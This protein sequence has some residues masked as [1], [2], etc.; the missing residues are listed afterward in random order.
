[1]LKAGDFD[2]LQESG[3]VLVSHDARFRSIRPRECAAHAVNIP[4]FQPTPMH[5]RSGA[6]R[7]ALSFCA[8][9]LPAVPL[10]VHALPAGGQVAA[11]NVAITQTGNTMTLQQGSPHAIVNWQSFGIGAG[12]HLHLQQNGAD[13]AML[14]RVIGSDP[15][16][17]LGTLK[18]DG[19]LFL[20]NRNGILVGAGA[21]I[22]TAAFL[23]STL[24]VADADFLK[25]GALTL[26]GDSTAGVVNL[27]KITAREG[28]VLLLA[29]TVKNAG[30]ISAPNGTAGLGAG[31]EVFLASPDAPAFV[32]K[33]NLTRAPGETA[34]NTGV[35]NSGVIAA[36]QA[37][38]EAAGGSLYDLAVN[39]SGVIKATGLE[40]QPDGRILLTSAGGNVAVSGTAIAHNANG[41]GGEILIGGD[42]QG[43]NAAIANAANTQI[44]SSASLDASATAASADG[45]RV[46]VWAD[47]TTHY[48]GALSARGGATGGDGGFAEVSGKRRLAFAGTS[49]LSAPA[50]QRGTLLLDPDN[51]T[52]VAGS[53]DVP[54]EI[55]ISPPVVTWD[56]HANAGEDHEFG[57]D[58]LVALLANNSVW[59][60]AT[61][62]ITVNAPV[63]VASGGLEGAGLSFSASA[64][65]INATVSLANV[66]DG[67]LTFSHSFGG[68][69]TSLT[70]AA[71]A[72]IAA[73]SI[74]VGSFPITAF[75]GVVST[76]SLTYNGFSTATSFSATNP[77]NAIGK[78][79]LNTDLAD[80]QAIPFT[81]NVAVHSGTGMT[82]SAMI[83]GANDVTFSSAGDLT[84]RND[85]T[86]VSVITASGTTKLASTGGVLVNEVGPDL[87]AGTG[88]K[89]LYTSTT[90]DG[91]GF[92]LGGLSNFQRVSGVS[93]PDDPRDDLSKVLYRLDGL[94]TIAADD[95]SKTYGAA[96]PTFTATYTGGSDTDLIVLP[97]F[98]IQEGSATNVG[99][100]TIV[101]SGATADYHDIAYVNGTLTIDPATLTYVAT[102]ATR[103]IVASDP[104]FSGTVTGFVNG[105]TLET[106]TTGT[107][108]FSTTATDSSPAGTYALNGS[109]LSAL[110]G[111]YVFVQA[112]ANATAFT[113]TQAGLIVITADSFT[114]LYGQPNPS[115]TASYS[116]GTASDLTIL[117]Q[118]SIT[119]GPAINVGTYEIVPFGADSNTHSLSY[120]NGT[121][122]IDPAILT[123]VAAP[124]TRTMVGSNP[125][126]SGTVTGFVNGD[127]LDTAT[128]G[129]LVFATN[130][131]DSSPAGTYALN[132]SGLNA[133]HGNYVF[134]QA[135][136][137]ANAFSITSAPQLI[138]RANDFT[139]LYGAPLPEFTASYSGG[140]AANL[141]ALPTFSIQG[142]SAVNVG[143]YVIVPSGA[144][145]NTHA[146]SYVN[147][148]FT[149]TPATLTY[150]AH[151]TN[152]V[153]GDANPAF[154]GT[155][156]G[157]VN[158]D[159]L[160][161]ATT[162]AL[163]F[164]SPAT[165]ASN[166]GTH[167]ING[168]GLTANFGNYIF[169][170]AFANLSALTI[171][172]APL[173]AVFANATRAYGAANPD[174]T[175]TFTG[176]RN[177]DTPAMLTGYAWGTTATATSSVGNYE[178]GASGASGVPNYAI[179]TIPA[180]LTITPATLTYVADPASRFYGV[181]NPL[182]SGTVT[183]FVNGE[184]L[185]TATTGTLT[186]NSPA[187]T[188]SNV[189]AY[190]INGS[191]L[192]ANHG[193]YVF[194]HAAAN[195]TAFTVNRAPLTLEGFN[196]TAVY[197][198][199]IPA[200]GYSLI[201]P[202]G[203]PEAAQ[204]TGLNI[205]LGQ[206]FFTG[207]PA[208]T[209][210]FDVTASGTAQN[211]EITHT[212]PGQLT[213]APA[214]LTLRGEHVTTYYG[215][216]V[217][218]LGFSVSG[219]VGADTAAV[220]SGVRLGREFSATTA[221]GNY[222]IGFINTGSA[223]N[224][225][226]TEVVNG[227][228]TIARRPLT[229][230]ADDLTTVTGGIPPLTSTLTGST[231]PGGPPFQIGYNVYR[232]TVEN[233]VPRLTPIGLSQ[234]TPSGE[235]VI[236]PVIE[237]DQAT[238]GHP[239]AVYDISL[240]DGTLTLH[241]SH[242]NFT[243]LV[244]NTDAHTGD[245]VIGGNF[246]LSGYNL[247]LSPTNTVTVK[248][249]G[250]LADALKDGWA[251]LRIWEQPDL[252]T[253]MLDADANRPGA[254]DEVAK[255]LSDAFFR[256]LDRDIPL[257]PGMAKLLP[258][259]IDELNALKLKQAAEI[260]ARYKSESI[261]PSA[262]DVSSITALNST[263]LM[264]AG[265]ALAQE[266]AALRI[267]P[268]DATPE[269]FLQAYAVTRG[270]FTASAVK[271]RVE[272][273]NQLTTA[274]QNVVNRLYTGGL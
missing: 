8:V 64:I 238:S 131:T 18:A 108:A 262:V 70:T 65:A 198:S 57:A 75:N 200:L 190:A 157:F 163:A 123:Y 211:Y 248:L 152:R 2:I 164:T 69:G 222:E 11:G 171:E 227:S 143:T 48:A 109:G 104:L 264:K 16:Q 235:Y 160:Q 56:E 149:I 258:V 178:I 218:T 273:S 85:A 121:L 145:S 118:F 138:I 272:T 234:N 237:F 188:T 204:L 191:G 168:G 255:T 41:S 89:L 67:A 120:V 156:T 147:G 126:F 205:S 58:N 184:T 201:G 116:G 216:P 133:L 182:F 32:I 66:T 63:V 265:D 82:V 106:A 187:T 242:L 23:A 252:D 33:T 52:I 26:T 4:P 215:D 101:G 114:R 185:A 158:G 20:I 225:I 83:G 270:E 231:V 111:N 245:L 50:G 112:G 7:L 91:S 203:T 260:V 17:L 239:L 195:A 10:S 174:F 221:P 55:N 73:P 232:R 117:P 95:K 241:P 5:S 59:L 228:V 247:H 79:I 144:A 27:G 189:G 110:H 267:L 177:G 223:Q 233:G 226:V 194:S 44:T 45:G 261:D 130:A 249:G 37:Q 24:D 119:G 254:R 210:S 94:L 54:S 137:N 179:T 136:S 154:S 217:P 246:H 142:G 78:F 60:S 46:I 39:H 209:Y 30:D 1:M 220:L 49:D 161:T 125:L 240:V 257:P 166:A 47:N 244:A 148:I 274:I 150:I 96:T 62:T 80:P 87:F 84:M 90:A 169:E 129:T 31:T 153:Y 53:T 196:L 256:C 76:E 192:T 180:T 206:A 38:L 202:N 3:A 251:I 22:D 42:Y 28:N 269:Q 103:T 34:A 124:A 12:E 36:A 128:T 86:D 181:T 115:F 43:K 14:A 271:K 193:N 199:P 68:T 107:L 197:G 122:T 40:R 162:G 97:T 167:A 146:L 165:P 88:R 71:G 224:Y 250:N 176:F 236:R 74:R 100:Y 51:I 175:P 25:G 72:M 21:T 13:A 259:V 113:I 102:P 230:T 98:T 99:T 105:D 266:I 208:G 134:V 186:W 170:D 229:I 81:G 172:R 29:Q 61:D 92:D 140:T 214:P 139:R 253:F 9:A 213:I 219:L 127:T 173:T 207:T 19:K 35:D 77:A 263:Q 183:G 268:R 141:T 159:T 155:V 6:R 15:S 243:Q 151:P 132:G 93:F 135:A 212:I